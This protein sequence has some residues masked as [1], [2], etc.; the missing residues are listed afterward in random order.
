MIMKKALIFIIALTGILAF[1]SCEKSG[2][3]PVL[4]MENTINPVVKSPTTN[5]SYILLEAQKEDVFA[6]FKWDPA[7]YSITA[8]RNWNL[9]NSDKLGEVN[10]TVQ[11]DTESDNFSSPIGLASTTGTSFSISVGDMNGKLLAMGLATDEPHNLVFRVMAEIVNAT[12]YE[13]AYSETIKLT[14]TPFAAEIVY[15]PIYLL[16]DATA[17]GWDNN[18]ALPMVGLSETSFAIVATLA[19]EGKYLKF[20]KTLGAWAPQWGTDGTGTPEA[21]PLV[22]RPTE[23][24]P[25]P[26]SIPAPAIAGDYRI[27]AD[28][29][30]LTYT[31]TKASEILYLLGDATLA[32]WDNAGALPLQRVSPGLFE[33]TTTLSGSGAFKFIETL[34]QWAPQYGTDATGTGDGGT[35]VLRPNETVPDSP[36][37]PS[38]SA[39]TYKIIVDLAKMKYTVLPQ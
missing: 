29:A 32:G 38:P 30:N 20:I 9:L 37:I 3:E 2:I 39:G 23:D 34:G 4:D 22:Y 6:E 17:P 14:V 21:G 28:I 26:A 25:D 18:N 11:M 15:P 24:V 5:T 36:A 19:G 31:I 27:T 10:Y 8:G 33:I 35:L 12:P 13:N 16:G 1:S 7:E